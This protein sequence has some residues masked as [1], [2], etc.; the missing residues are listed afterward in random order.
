VSALTHDFAADVATGKCYRG[1]I[2]RP[3]VAAAN[4]AIFKIFRPFSVLFGRFLRPLNG[5][6]LVVKQQQHVCIGHGNQII[7]INVVFAT[8]L[9]IFFF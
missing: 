8:L 6:F 4:F 7:N 1:P 3:I 5:C 2:L 9:L